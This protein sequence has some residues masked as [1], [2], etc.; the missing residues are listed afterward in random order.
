ME[1]KIYDS[2]RHTD[3]NGNE[4][5]LARE[6]AIA[7][8]YKDYR[9]FK[10]IIEKAQKLCVENIAKTEDHFVESTEM[11]EVGCGA[12]DPDGHLR[13]QLFFDGDTVWTTQKRIAEIFQVEVNTV[14]Y[15]LK[16]IFDSGELNKYSVIRKDWITAADGKKYETK[17]YNLD[18]IIAASYHDK[19]RVIQDRMYLS[20]FDK[21]VQRLK[22]EMGI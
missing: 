22:D 2:I 13:I 6:L 15:H 18:V 9:N 19:Y 8:G 4:Y 12:S 16:E 7:V 17:L 21:E 10:G 3:E 14:S 11:V 1:E 5:W 20:D